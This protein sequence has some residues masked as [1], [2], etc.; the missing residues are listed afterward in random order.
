MFLHL[1]SYR[2]KCLSRDVTL[3]FWTLL[4]PLILGTLFFFAFGNLMKEGGSFS[5]VRTAVVDTPAYRADA[6][7]QNMLGE[8][9]QPGEHQLLNLIVTDAESAEKL[10]EKGGVDGIILTGE[11]IELKVGRSGLNPSI[12]KAILDEYA[13][14]AGTAKHILQRN[15]AAGPELFAAISDHVVYTEQISLSS[16]PPNSLLT[17]F[18]ALIA[19]TCMFGSFWG[20]KNALHTQANLSQ[21]ALRCSVA[22][23]HK[24][25]MVLSDTAAAL[26]IAVM[27][28]LGL[29]T[30]LAFVLG[31]DFGRAIGYILLTCLVGSLA[32]VAW[33][34]LLGSLL[35]LSEG[36]KNGI[37]VG[38]NLLLSFLAGLMF[39]NMKDI[40]ANK[41]PVLSYVNPVA[42]I[43][44]AL[45]SLYIFDNHSRFFLNIGLLCLIAAVFCT[46]GFLKL[47]GERYAG[48]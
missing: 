41:L 22:P 12:L 45:Y 34:T 32:G 18:Y 27:E 1:F 13:Q 11:A 29:L 15:P 31:V 26:V 28:V 6:A 21:Q 19:M 38:G 8:L 43:T 7:F 20:L 24:L 2:L 47:R 30:Y 48:L 17:Y 25:A 35:R 40:V 3:L 5:P 23:T 44:D 36:T 16:A 33:G 10:L 39:V 42:L 37:L 14:T 9:S 46:T 4:F